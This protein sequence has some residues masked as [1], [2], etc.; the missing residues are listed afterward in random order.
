MIGTKSDRI[1]ELMK[2]L[3]PKCCPVIRA[4]DSA[5]SELGKL[6]ANAMLA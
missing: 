3:S 2:L 6:M 1:F 5:S 4:S